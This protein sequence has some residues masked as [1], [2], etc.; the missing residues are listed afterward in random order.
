MALNLL[1]VL[2]VSTEI[3]QFREPESY[4]TLHPAKVKTVILKSEK[5]HPKPPVEGRDRYPVHSNT[6]THRPRHTHRHT[7]SP[8]SWCVSVY[9]LMST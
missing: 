6:K 2:C 7:H 1:T 3:S 9:R 8:S 4:Q 5:L